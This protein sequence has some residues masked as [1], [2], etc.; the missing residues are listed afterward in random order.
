MRR[1]AAFQAAAES[2]AGENWRVW[3]QDLRDG[4]PEAIDKAIERNRQAFEFAL[5]CQWLADRQLGRA[6]ER[7]RKHAASRS[8]SI[9]ISR[10]ARL[11]TERKSWAHDAILAR[12]VTIG[13]PPDPFS[14][15]GQ[16]WNLPA[17]NP[18]AGAREG[19]ASL[20]A[21]YR[22]NMRHAGMLRIDHAMGLQRLFLI[23]EGAKPGGGRLPLLSAR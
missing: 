22:A 8:A 16:N 13:A 14:A 9:A 18:L 21:L 7:A 1:F 11:R 3:P 4:E 19:W 12:G 6:A 20:S 5:F 2:D 10:S 23:P 17:P 15:Q